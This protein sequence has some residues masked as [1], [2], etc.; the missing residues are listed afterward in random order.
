MLNTGYVQKGADTGIIPVDHV[1]NMIVLTGGNC[2]M[3]GEDGKPFYVNACSS[4]NLEAKWE[5]FVRGQVAGAV[6]GLKL[7]ERSQGGTC[8]GLNQT[9]IQEVPDAGTPYHYKSLQIIQKDVVS[10]LEV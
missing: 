6:G 7:R 10:Q 2:S 5:N 4:T 8:E 1:A 9:G 3:K